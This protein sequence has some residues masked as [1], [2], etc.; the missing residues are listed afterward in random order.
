LF[1]LYACNN[2]I[3]AERISIE[4]ITGEYNKTSIYSF[5]FWLKWDKNKRVGRYVIICY[6]SPIFTKAVMDW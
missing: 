3:T 4:S 6:S 2:M 5:Q 1:R